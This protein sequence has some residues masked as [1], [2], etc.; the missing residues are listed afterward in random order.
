MVQEME[1]QADLLKYSTVVQQIR[2]LQTTG[3]ELYVAR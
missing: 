2:H 1:R 3:A